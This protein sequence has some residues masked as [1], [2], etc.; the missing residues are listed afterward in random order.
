MG[1]AKYVSTASKDPSTQVGAVIVD[2]QKR[3]VSLGFN[4]LPR[5]IDDSQARLFDRETKY[6]M[7]VH[8]ERN[9]MLF[10][11]RS[12]HGCTLY[13]WPFQPCS[14]CA[15]L[16]VQAGIER[17]VSVPNDNPRWQDDFRLANEMFAETG[18]TLD[19]LTDA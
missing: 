7:I 8:A 5:G 12:M 4:G 14:Q 18:I 11:Q 13:T 19:L 17:V 3:V 16:V 10:A 6:K 1:L 2:R 9:A 15:G